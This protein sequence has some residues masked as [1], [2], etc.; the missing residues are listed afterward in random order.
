MKAVLD[1]KMKVT[2]TGKCD[3][4]NRWYPGDEERASCCDSIREPSRSYPWSFYK[5]C[6]SRKHKRQ[7]LLERPSELEREAL[8][9]TM[10]TAPL[11]VNDTGLLFHVAKKLMGE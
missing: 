2:P 9:M 1:Y 3:K 11:H 10:E 7:L 6:W 5:H 8:A 4:G